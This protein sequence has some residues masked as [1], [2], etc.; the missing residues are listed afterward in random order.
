MTEMGP[1]PD[2][3]QDTFLL[4]L[5][6]AV[7]GPNGGDLRATV[8]FHLD[9][10]AAQTS[11]VSKEGFESV[12]PRA[13]RTQSLA[14][15]YRTVAHIAS[16]GL[17][18]V[19]AAIQ[20]CLDREVAIKRVREDR[21]IPS[22]LENLVRES[23]LLAR[24]DHPNITPIYAL[25]YDEAGEP[26]IVMKRIKGKPWNQYIGTRPEFVAEKDGLRFHLTVLCT[27]CR[28]VE[29]AH[30]L[31]IVHLDLK[32]DNVMVGEFGEVYLLD[33]GVAVELD[34]HE[35][36][37]MDTFYGTPRFAAPEMFNP[38][39]PLT[40]KTDVYLLGGILHEVLAHRP[41]H[42]AR[43][44][45]EII[46]QASQSE[47][48]EYGPGI[49]Q[50]LAEIVHKATAKNSDERFDSARAFREAIQRFLDNPD[51]GAAI[52]AAEDRLAKFKLAV[53]SGT[54]PA[55]E[56][57]RMAFECRYAFLQILKKAPWIAQ[58]ETGLIQCVRHLFLFVVGRGLLVEARPLL[59]EILALDPPDDVRHELQTAL[60]SE[61]LR[62][63]QSQELNT[64]IQYKLLEQLQH[65]ASTDKE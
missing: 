1:F 25:A 56:V 17:A 38:R 53:S 54:T 26:L 47:P 40:R 55:F 20:N 14:E 31:G 24:L 61:E 43:T 39:H 3:V 57:Y 23:Q 18:V 37:I 29:Y 19:D 42:D 7:D 48:K 4:T 41:L 16:G 58:A 36:H 60:K 35:R 27:V 52:Q 64:Q 12:L 34:E 44:L 22:N 33:W 8:A 65:S 21:K 63:L 9:G 15:P 11:A 28:A 32:T 49:P 50:G 51:F 59:K 6:E 46:V 2:S 13:I 62:T 45:Q 5:K 30:S 10:D